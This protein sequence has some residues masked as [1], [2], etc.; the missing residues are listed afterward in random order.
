MSINV[1]ELEIAE[2]CIMLFCNNQID[3]TNS[4]QGPL[5]QCLGP[6]RTQWGE[7]SLSPSCPEGRVQKRK[8]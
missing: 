8:G 4:G 6:E 5:F 3:F 7:K 2:S 1:F